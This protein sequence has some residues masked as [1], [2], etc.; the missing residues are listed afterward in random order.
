VRCENVRRCVE[1]EELRVECE[2]VRMWITTSTTT[3]KSTMLYRV[4]G[5]IISLS[6]SPCCRG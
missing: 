5:K 3:T 4:N 6:L 2:E 1:C